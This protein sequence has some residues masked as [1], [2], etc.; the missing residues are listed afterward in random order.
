MVMSSS[1]CS[2]SVRTSCPP[3]TR[4]TKVVRTAS[5]TSAPPGVCLGQPFF[6]LCRF[7]P[8]RFSRGE[9]ST[10][11]STVLRTPTPLRSVKPTWS[12]DCT[13]RSRRWS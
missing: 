11:R 4:E 5:S 8:R 6:R 2:S 1:S 9:S 3:P 10:C 7:S 12:L 13:P